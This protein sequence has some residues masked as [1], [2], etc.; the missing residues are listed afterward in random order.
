MNAHRTSIEV[1][2]YNQFGRVVIGAIAAF[3]IAAVAGSLVY[4]T[5]LEAQAE[6][7]P[8]LSVL[9]HSA[10]YFPAQFERNPSA[11]KGA[12]FEY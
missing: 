8:N 11:K 4:V 5:G 10:R 7:M 3:V 2:N 1:L 6:S 9:D 12:A